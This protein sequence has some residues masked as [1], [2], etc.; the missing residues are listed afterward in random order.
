MKDL[1]VKN[2]VL[3]IQNI[4]FRTSSLNNPFNKFSQN[5]TKPPVLN[6]TDLGTFCFL[7]VAIGFNL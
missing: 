4:F 7:C 5:S 2:S 6:N 3:P 1:N